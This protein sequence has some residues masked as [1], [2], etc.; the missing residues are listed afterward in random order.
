MSASRV[1]SALRDG[2]LCASGFGGSKV[3]KLDDRRRI[4]GGSKPEGGRKEDGI[5]VLPDEEDPSFVEVD[6]SRR[7]LVEARSGEVDEYEVLRVLVE[8]FRGLEEG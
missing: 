7:V 1:G 4:K 5:I 3:D 2:E 8:A 6:A